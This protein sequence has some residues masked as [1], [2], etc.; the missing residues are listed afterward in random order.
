M[1][2]KWSS[3]VRDVRTV[4]PVLDAL[5]SAGVAKSSRHHL[6]STDDLRNAL[7]RWRQRQH[8]SYG[9]GY[10][11]LHGSPGRV[12]IGRSAVDLLA[13]GQG[14]PAQALKGKVLHFGSCSVL[15][16]TP[17]ELESLRRALGVRAMTGFT[18]DVDWFDS[19]AF[20]LLLFDSLAYYKR[21]DAVERDLKAR[22][23]SMA[24]RLGF[25]IVR[26]KTAR[27]GKGE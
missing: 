9:I 13:L 10:L 26:S 4:G 7:G 24:R 16:Q 3:S 1:E 18:E 17:T 20:E 14:L 27:G 15:K 11:A 21:L 22:A 6:N 25:R 2:G 8:A 12:H 5:T 19:L 23:G